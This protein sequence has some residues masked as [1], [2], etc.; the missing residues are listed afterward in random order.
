MNRI[1]IL[2]ERVANQIAAGEVV[3]RPASVVKELIENALDAQATEITVTIRGGGRALIQVRDN[4]HGMSRDDALLSLERHATSKLKESDDLDRI[5]SYGFRGEA[6]PSIASVSRFRLATQLHEAP[7]GTELIVSGG[8]LTEVRDHGMAPGTLVEVRSLF[9]N[10]PARRK[11]LRTVPTELAHVQHQVALAALAQPSVGFELHIDER[12]PQRWPTGQSP[13]QRIAAV[14]G[15]EW[16]RRLTPVSSKQK[17]LTL[18]GW[19]GRP[20]VSRSNRQEELLFVNG[21][22][23]DNRTFHY[24]LLEGYHNTL[25]RGRFPVAVVNLELDPSAVDVNV[26]PAK[27]EIRFRDDATIRAFLVQAVRDALRQLPAAPV[28]VTL[29]TPSSFGNQSHQTSGATPITNS[30]FPSH[31]PAVVREAPTIFGTAPRT[32]MPETQEAAS[33]FPTP[34]VTFSQTFAH[35][36]PLQNLRMIGVIGALYFAAESPEGL[37]L[38]DQHAAHERVLFEKLLARV[39]RQEVAS[40]RL[41]LPSTIELPPRQ[42]EFLSG[43][44]PSLRAVGVDLHA[45]GPTTFLLDG[46]PPMVRLR[47]P[48]MFVLDLVTTLQEDGGET[49]KGRRLSEEVIAKTVCRQAVKARDALAPAECEQLLIDL[50]NCN[51]P[52]TCPHGRPTMIRLSWRDLGKLF[53]RVT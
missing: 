15:E 42:A 48:R 31:A 39:Q 23:V 38:V 7:V 44:L 41:L 29:P 40:Q 49:A 32:S 51:S 26:H 53:G 50:F 16:L 19:I 11:F 52:M 46:L 13:E 4:G 28:E 22:P 5:H 25:M 27:R 1:R 17:G 30:P 34:A 12:P 8:K 10:M 24:G 20:G 43:Q 47:D 9:F 35:Q 33:L 3:D 6:L 45:F 14:F 37:V 18:I 36:K 2:S 21:R